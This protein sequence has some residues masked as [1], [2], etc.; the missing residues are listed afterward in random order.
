VSFSA[1]LPPRTCKTANPPAPIKSKSPTEPYSMVGRL[2]RR[3]YICEL[4]GLVA[5][6]ENLVVCRSQYAR[7][8][9][10][11]RSTQKTALLLRAPFASHPLTHARIK[12]V[13][14]NFQWQRNLYRGNVSHSL[15][16]TS[17]PPQPRAAQSSSQISAEVRSFA[18][19]SQ[20]FMAAV[21]PEGCS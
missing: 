10:I 3:I 15:A 17:A 9:G 16:G 2:T 14:S 8:K 4:D 7:N 6:P 19:G 12:S 21:L 1:R 20:I 13:S 11:A 5:I 18:L